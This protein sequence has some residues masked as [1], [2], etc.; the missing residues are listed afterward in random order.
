MSIFKR[1]YSIYF[2]AFVVAT[3]V[4]VGG[5]YLGKSEREII[6]VN[7][8]GEPAES[9]KVTM[10]PDQIKSYLGKDVNFDLFLQVWDMIKA[11][12]VDQPVSET[13]LF[14]GALRGLVDGL[15]DPYSVFMEPTIS[16]EFNE[17]L[18]GRFEG[19]GAEI[20]IKR[21]VL[22]VVAPLSGSPAE[23][24]GIK[25][26][27]SILKIDDVSTEGMNANEAVSRIKGEKGTTV[28]LLILHNGDIEPVEISVIRDTIHVVSVRW[29]M[30]DGN[31]AYINMTNFNADTTS[32]FTGIVKEVVAANPSGI[33]FDL[34]NNSGGYL[35]TSIDVA[36]AWIENN[37]VV[38]E[39]SNNSY[40]EYKSNGNPAF[41]GIPTVVLINGGSASASE[42]VAGA[43]QDYG[44]AHLIGEQSFGKG[45][46]QVLEELSDGSS[47]KYTIAKWYTPKDRTIDIEGIKPDEEIELTSEDFSE[48]RDPQ[49]DKALEY[50]KNL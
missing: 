34:R 26:K 9:G 37:I 33:I 17:S 25:P 45:S 2:I 44:L 6:V 3:C 18:N 50:L 35:Q 42:I 5:F 40:K 46:V 12:Y 47:I 43:L 39:R 16:E 15:D 38:R 7:K 29:E 28:V 19:I 31:I 24:A 49:M 20:A 23:K 30:K 10:N 32:L 1:K 4:F 41:A 21:N 11:K 8:N 14:Y 27:D 48:D 13:K 22:T 36:S